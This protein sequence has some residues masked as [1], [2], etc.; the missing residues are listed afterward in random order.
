MPASRWPKRADLTFAQFVMLTPFPGTL[1]F[2][3]W[4]KAMGAQPQKVG[5]IPVTRHWLIP[6]ARRP[7]VYVDHPVMS[8]EEIRD[9]TQRRLGSVLFGSEHLGPVARGEDAEGA[10]GVRADLE[11]LPADVRQHRNRDRQRAGEP[12]GPVG[13]IDGE[14]V[15]SPLRGPSHARLAVALT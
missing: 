14:A 11:D 2:A 1:D 12:I 10:A 6:Q 5:G 13:A 15:P 7:K 4:E 3:A 9:R 8:A